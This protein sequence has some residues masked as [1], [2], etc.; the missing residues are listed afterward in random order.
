M[1]K[2]RM[3]KNSTKNAI[4]IQLEEPDASPSGGGAI[5]SIF[6]IVIFV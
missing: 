2:Y 6:S 5:N 1:K 3:R 4:L